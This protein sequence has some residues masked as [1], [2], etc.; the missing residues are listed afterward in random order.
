MLASGLSADAHDVL[1]VD[2][3]GLGALLDHGGKGGD[4]RGD[5]V[6]RGSA[7]N[8]PDV[9]GRALVESAE[10][11]PPDRRRGGLDRARPVLGTDPG[12]RLD[13]DEV[14]KD[15][16]LRRRR[17]DLLA[18]RA[19]VVEHVADLRAQ[20]LDLEGLGAA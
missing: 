18:D 10:A 13:P 7:A 12:M 15:L 8:E 11:H 3:F 6:A 20:L 9:R 17:R 5:D 1:A 14:G 4:E 19:G 2:D 16:H